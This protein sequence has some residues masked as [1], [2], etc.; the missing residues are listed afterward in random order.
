MDDVFLSL[1]KYHLAGFGQV[2]SLEMMNCVFRAYGAIDDI[3][4]KENA[5]RIM[6][7]Y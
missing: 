2:I 1:I 3:A 5:V 4:I 6:G 7:A